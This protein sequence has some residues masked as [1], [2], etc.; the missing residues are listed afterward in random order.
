MRITYSPK[1]DAAYIYLIDVLASKETGTTFSYDPFET[2][3]MIN[4]DFDSDGKLVGI[5]VIDAS[6]LLP[7]ELLDRAERL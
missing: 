2:G 4:L 6:R 7:R 3:S 1:V 5:E